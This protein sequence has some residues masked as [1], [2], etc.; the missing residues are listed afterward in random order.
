VGRIKDEY[1]FSEWL[2]IVKTT[3]KRG[4]LANSENQSQY[5][6]YFL[7]QLRYSEMI[8]LAKHKKI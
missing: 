3:K 8:V 4:F 7:Y 1:Y 5:K 6:Q 2:I